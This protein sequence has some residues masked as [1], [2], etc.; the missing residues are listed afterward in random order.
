MATGTVKWF[1]A[2]KAFGLMQPDSGGK[3]ASVHIRAGERLGLQG[4]REGQK[5]SYDLQVE[6]GKEAA[7][8][9]KT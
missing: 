9:L 7:A 5:I 8:N 4:L 2:T 3:D 1:N 6:R